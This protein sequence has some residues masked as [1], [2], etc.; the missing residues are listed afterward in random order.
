MLERFFKKFFHME[1][2]H[3]IIVLEVFKYMKNVHVCLK[4][5]FWYSNCYTISALL[6]LF[7]VQV[8][9]L[10]NYAINNF[11][12][13]NQRERD[14]KS[15]GVV[16]VVNGREVVVRQSQ[17]TSHTKRFTFDRAF[18]PHARQVCDYFYT[19]EICN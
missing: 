1:F 8:I 10:T 17:Q 6:Y 3:L 2:F 15:L 4:L 18:G 9:V 11:R 14:I 7:G 5:Y 13:L 16:E 12:P 19:I